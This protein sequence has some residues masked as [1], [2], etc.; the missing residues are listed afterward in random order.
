MRR[1]RLWW[2]TRA[3]DKAFYRW[4]RTKDESWLHRYFDFRD[5]VC[6]WGDEEE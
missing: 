2:L 1:L 6:A 3:R 5:K 4:L